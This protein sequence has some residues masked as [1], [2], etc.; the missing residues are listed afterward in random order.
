MLEK[1][2]F[3]KKLRV[4]VRICFGSSK[5]KLLSARK[6]KGQLHATYGE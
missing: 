5:D 4:K 6:D 2:T 3:I 1:I